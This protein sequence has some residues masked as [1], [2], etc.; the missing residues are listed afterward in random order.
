MKRLLVFVLISFQL[1]G[2]AGSGNSYASTGLSIQNIITKDVTQINET[3]PFKNYSADATNRHY[4]KNV[5][6]RWQLPLD[7]NTYNTLVARNTIIQIN[8]TFLNSHA[9]HYKPIGLLLIFPQH[10]FWWGHSLHLDRIPAF[11]VNKLNNY[12]DGLARLFIRMSLTKS[13]LTNS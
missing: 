12:P 9:F 10:Y 13:I 7:R 6:Q 1:P 4:L 11:I 5:P 3:S 8:N 2:F